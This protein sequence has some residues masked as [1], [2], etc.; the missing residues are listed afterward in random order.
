MSR[1]TLDAHGKHDGS[2]FIMTYFHQVFSN[3]KLH[4]RGLPAE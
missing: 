4:G 2:A 3:Q 1:C